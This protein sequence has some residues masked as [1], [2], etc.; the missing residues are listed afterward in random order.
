MVRPQK[1]LQSRG[2][3]GGGGSWSPTKFIT[4]RVLRNAFR[5]YKHIF[6]QISA[7]CTGMCVYERYAPVKAI[8]DTVFLGLSYNLCLDILTVKM[9]ID[10]KS[11][12]VGLYPGFQRLCFCYRSHGSDILGISTTGL[13]SQGSSMVAGLWAAKTF[14]L[15]VTQDLRNGGPLE[16]L[17]IAKQIKTKVPLHRFL[18]LM[19]NYMICAF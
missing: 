8:L 7:V 19:F 2:G 11:W 17:S 16:M 18:Y 13:F 15:R 10:F 12:N 5:K 4:F 6:F 1:V 9:L 3:R 14:L